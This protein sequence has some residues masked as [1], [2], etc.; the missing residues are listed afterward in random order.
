MMPR[1]AARLPLA[2]PAELL[3]RPDVSPAAKLAWMALASCLAGDGLA[4]ASLRALRSVVGLA[5][6][7]MR[8]A[9]A[10]LADAGLATPVKL[11]GGGTA[12]A[13]QVPGPGGQIDRRS[14]RPSVRMTVGQND[15][16]A[17]NEINDLPAPPE[18]AAGPPHTPPN[19]AP[20]ENSS[21]VEEKKGGAGGKGAPGKAKRVPTSLP[22]DFAPSERLLAHIREHYPL[23]DASR[24]LSAFRLYWLEGKGKGKLK[25]D[26]QGAFRVWCEKAQAWAEERRLAAGSAAAPSGARAAAPP[27]AGR[28]ESAGIRRL[29][30]IIAE[31]QAKRRTA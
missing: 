30:E 19:S 7:T 5:D 29:R 15:R 1:L 12:W 25:S 4:R 27:P 9:L 14:N 10:E 2:V 20:R 23:V 28:P 18:A 6:K 3:A 21:V 24:E 11:P 16:S 17:P 22:P 13:V 31:A 8:R 26:W